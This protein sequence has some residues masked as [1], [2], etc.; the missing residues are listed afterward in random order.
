MHNFEYLF[1]NMNNREAIGNQEF[2]KKNSLGTP[3]VE[4]FLDLAHAKSV[5]PENI[6]NNQEFRKQLEKRKELNDNLDAVQSRL[7]SSDT[8]LESAISQSRLSE[9]Q[10]ASLYSSLSGLL[11]TDQDYQRIILY[12]PFEFLPDKDWQP[13]EERLRQE[14][15]KF[16][17]AYLET[18]NNLLSIHDVRTNFVN[19]DIPESKR[20]DGSLTRVVKAAHLIPKLVEKGFI[21]ISA[22]LKLMEESQ[23][24]TLKDSI[25]DTLPTLYDFGLLTEKDL[26][27]MG[28]SGDRLINNMARIINSYKNAKNKTTDKIPEAISL[29]NIQTTLQEKISAI[30]KEDYGDIAPKRK[31]WLMQE[32]KLEA[33]KTLS[34]DISS[35]I[36]NG[37]LASE[38]IN[39]FLVRDADW[40]GKQVLIEG[41]RQ[42]VESIAVTDPEKAKSTYAYFEENLLKLWKNTYSELEEPLFKTFHRLH[43]LKIIDNQQL[44]SLGISVPKLIGP[45]SDNMSEMEDELEEIKTMAASIEQSKELSQLIFPVIITFGSRL[46]GYGLKKSDVDIGI[47]VR[48]ETPFTDRTKIQDLLKKTFGQDK[49]KGGIVEFWLE[50]DDNHLKISSQTKIDPSLGKENWT[51]VL[52]GGAWEGNQDAIKKLHGELLTPYLFDTDKL[53]QGREARGVYL[54]EMESDILQYRLMHKG[55]ECFF[56]PLGGIKT[57]HAKDIDG[58]SMFWDSGY[59]QLATKLFASRVFLPKISK[60]KN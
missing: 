16:K 54:E 10:I 33:I 52:L 47:F 14:S 59:R 17:K 58:E 53:I 42:V 39:D 8:T 28:K 31:S 45:F 40:D 6:T 15:E 5:W 29:S 34:A 4:S 51:H 9:E 2:E 36:Q 50:E 18:W 30:E 57:P 19:G 41:I 25:A 43:Q 12:I 32:Q 23:D 48:P 44:A 22:V 24:Q 56:P 35:A 38:E 7:P 21:E 3:L 46:K 11:K 26:E 20:D 60:G 49:M 1:M 37:T 13:K 55:Y 27:F